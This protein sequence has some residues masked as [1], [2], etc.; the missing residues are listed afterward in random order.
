M[1]PQLAAPL[2]NR[3]HN[4]MPS[5]IVNKSGAVLGVHF[6]QKAGSLRSSITSNDQIKVGTNYSVLFANPGR[7]VSVGDT[8]DIVIGDLKL[9]AIEV[10]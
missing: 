5:A 4:F 7:H 6:T 10:T 1:D 9:A 2:L 3:A 8:I